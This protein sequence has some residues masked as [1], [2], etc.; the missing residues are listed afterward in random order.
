MQKQVHTHQGDIELR[1]D[2]SLML[3]LYNGDPIYQ[4]MLTIVFAETLRIFY[5]YL[6]FLLCQFG[7]E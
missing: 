7:S 2:H 1:D 5:S 4:F 6:S 3:D